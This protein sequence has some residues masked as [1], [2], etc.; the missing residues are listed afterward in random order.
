MTDFWRKRIGSF[1]FAGRGVRLLISAEHN[2]WIH[3]GFTLAVI[4]FSLWW[5]VSAT[6]W[7]LLI[8]SIGV[9]LAAEA[10]NTA[11]EKL[12]DLV[13]PDYHKLAG[14][15]KDLAAGAV[16]LTAIAAALVGFIIFV[17]KLWNWWF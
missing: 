11:I 8:L 15:A 3:L 16:L 4:G 2:A 10:F 9:V 5:E 7:C 1:K 17:P 13:S 14:Q 12:T 6:E